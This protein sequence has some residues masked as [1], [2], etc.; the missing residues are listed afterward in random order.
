[1]STK[2]RADIGLANITPELSRAAKR[3][4]RIVSALFGICLNKSPTLIREKLKGFIAVQRCTGQVREQGA[5]VNIHLPKV[6]KNAQPLG[7]GNV[8]LEQVCLFGF[9]KL[10]LHPTGDIKT[11]RLA[12]ERAS[13]T[14]KPSVVVS[15]GVDKGELLVVLA[16]YV[17]GG[18][19]ANYAITMQGPYGSVATRRRCWVSECKE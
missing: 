5:A 7:V 9:L 2:T 11:Q 18:H 8:D 12:R 6:A 10:T 14:N 3:I 17:I 1:M 19:R 15:Q 13:L 16:F 4:E